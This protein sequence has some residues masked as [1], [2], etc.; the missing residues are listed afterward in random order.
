[1]SR[2]LERLRDAFFQIKDCKDD[3]QQRGWAVHDDH[4]IISGYL[5][6]LLQLLVRTATSCHSSYPRLPLWPSALSYLPHP[7]SSSFSSFSLFPPSSPSLLILSSLPPSL[8]LQC[9]AD[10]DISRRVIKEDK[11]EN[12]LTL[13]EFYHLVC[14]RF[15]ALSHVHPLWL[16]CAFFDGFVL[17]LSHFT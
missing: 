8:P 10:P 5:S 17:I 16:M 3:T 12:V 9:D 14:S 2:D 4:H 11:Y 13:I 7:S 1:M 6:E 15:I